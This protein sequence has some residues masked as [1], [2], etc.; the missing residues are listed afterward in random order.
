MTTRHRRPRGG[1]RYRSGEAITYP[2]TIGTSA[3]QRLE[4]ELADLDDISNRRPGDYT[5]QVLA[6]LIQAR[7]ELDR[8]I[9]QATVAAVVDQGQ[10]Q[11]RVAAWA[12]ISPSALTKWLSAAK[13]GKPESADG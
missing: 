6:A 13:S 10:S 5:Q 3:A 9:E 7:T 1:E 12:S 4:R 8:A 2:A 11:R